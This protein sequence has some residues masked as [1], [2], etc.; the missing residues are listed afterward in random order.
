MIDYHKYELM[1][2]NFDNANK[3]YMS[4]LDTSDFVPAK[5]TLKRCACIHKEELRLWRK[6]GR[7][8]RR[9]YRSLKKLIRA[10]RIAD[11]TSAEAVLMFYAQNLTKLG[12]QCH[13]EE[14]K[15]K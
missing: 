9:F 15:E 11:S 1:K 7:E 4:L 3:V 13:D 10:G 12:E 5:H 8:N 6:I 2:E 14:K